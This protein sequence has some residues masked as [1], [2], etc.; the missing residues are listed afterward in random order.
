MNQNLAPL[1]SAEEILWDD[2]LL[3]VMQDF[4]ACTGSLHRWNP[5]T[6]LLEMVAH[7]GIP[8]FVLSKVME[9]PLGKGIAGVAAQ[10]REPVEL[11]NLQADLGGVAKEDARKTQAHGTIAVAIESSTGELLGTI[12]VGKSVA[13]DF[14]CEEKSR[15][16]NYAN[17]IGAKL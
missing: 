15:I 7:S 10:T 5:H 13:H 3:A 12:G 2:V 4:D 17:D 14:T 11:C 8:P 1:L 16:Q 6:Q 9:I